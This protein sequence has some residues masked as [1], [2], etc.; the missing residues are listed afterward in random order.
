MK[1]TVYKNQKTYKTEYRGIYSIN[2]DNGKRYIGLSE[3]VKERLWEHYKSMDDLNDVLPVH[4]AMRKHNFE[5]ELLE[6]CKGNNRQELCEREKYWIKYYNTYEDKTKGYNLTP[7]GDGAAMGCN[8]NSAKLNE[9][10]I[11]EVYDKLINHKELY[12]Y[13]IAAQYNISPDAISDINNGKRYYNEKFT[14]PLRTAPKPNVG[15]GINNH[16]S[17]FKDINIIYN[18]YED[19]KKR[20]LTLNQIAEKYDCSYT[21]ISQINQGKKYNQDNIEYPIRKTEQRKMKLTENDI[22]EIRKLLIETDKT[23]KEISNIFSIS[24]DVIQRINNG[25]SKSYFSDKYTYPLRA[26]KKTNKAVSTILESE[27]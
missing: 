13:Q 14:Y 7:G 22:Q 23:Q 1:L 18:I 12:I 3:R 4:E 6:E 24:T 20:E 17:K 25:T 27:E 15:T 26:N 9:E 21:L 8:N 11:K 10:Q 2:F 19:L 16:L 5:F